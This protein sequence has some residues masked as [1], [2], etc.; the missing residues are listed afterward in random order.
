MNPDKASPTRH[1]LLTGTALPSAAASLRSKL[2]LTHLPP[3]CPARAARSMT[4][5]Y[6]MP[7]LSSECLTHMT[8]VVADGVHCSRLSPSVVE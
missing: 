1:G 6:L 7:W 2:P 8:A 4:A 5:G 3:S